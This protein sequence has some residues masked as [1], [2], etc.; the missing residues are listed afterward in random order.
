[1]GGY[2]RGHAPGGG[3]AGCDNSTR[4]GNAGGGSK[5]GG[6]GGT[7]VGIV[8]HS[9]LWRTLIRLLYNGLHCAGG[10]VVL[11]HCEH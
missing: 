1:M 6:D 9:C 11:V 5:G 3:G 4:M 7:G 8:R 2:K 10:L